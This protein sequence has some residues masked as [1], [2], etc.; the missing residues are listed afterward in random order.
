MYSKRWIILLMLA[1]S[2]GAQS[3]E[4][5]ILG[6]GGVSNGLSIFG[7]PVPASTALHA[8]PVVGVLLGQDLYS[9]WSGEIRYLF[10]QR[11]F[12]VASDGASVGFSGQAHSLHYDLVYQR[13]TRDQWIRPYA[14]AGGGVKLFRGTGQ[15]TSYRPLMEDAY[16]TKTL[17]I[18]PMLTAGGGVKIQVGSRVM[19]RIDMRDEITRF[20]D[21]IV[22]AAP[23][24]KIEGWLHDFVPGVGFSWMF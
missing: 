8:G 14:A 7:A 3:R 22:A 21:K 24:R 13:R 16:L 15:E 12:R 10:E 5:G 2:G 6:G 4:I 9:H 19:L 17:Q 20:P 23:G 1:S 11:E 18:Q